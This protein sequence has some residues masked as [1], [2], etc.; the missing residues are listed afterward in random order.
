MANG[1]AG[2]LAQWCLALAAFGFVIFSVSAI[3]QR[4]MTTARAI[5]HQL[6]AYGMFAGFFITLLSLVV[7]AHHLLED[8]RLYQ[9]SLKGLAVLALVLFVVFL[10]GV[11][12]T[13][14]RSKSLVGDHPFQTDPLKLVSVQS[15]APISSDVSTK[16]PRNHVMCFDGTWNDPD[17]RT[18]VHRL[19]E[20][21]PPDSG[22]QPKRYANG[23]GVVTNVG[24]ALRVF[25]GATRNTLIGCATGLGAR[26]IRSKAY[27]EF[28]RTVR[29]GDRLFIFGFSRG[30]AIAR[31]VANDIVECGIPGSVSARYQRRRNGEGELLEIAV[32]E[33]RKYG[34]VPIVMLGLWDTVTAFGIPWLKIDPF[35]KLTIDP[36][37]EKAFHLVAIDEKR[38]AFDATLANQDGGN[39]EEIWFAGAHVN[40]GGGYEGHDELSDITLRF[41]MKRAKEARL[42]FTSLGEE[43]LAK[44]LERKGVATDIWTPKWWLVRTIRKIRGGTPGVKPRLHTSVLRRKEDAGCMYDPPNVAGL[45]VDRDYGVEFRD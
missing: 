28:V 25:G 40:V 21:L 13:L 4:R 2:I 7:A 43:F 38:K 12:V 8:F 30:A 22:E 26:K 32:L 17:S 15:I 33:P 16:A 41:M 1:L 42:Q 27:I 11:A 39:V 23:V 35:K 19:H 36:S 10:I 29:P 18:N 5:A 34:S 31:M 9:M 44:E 37:V 3:A 6:A 14:G 20:F 24:A 45:K